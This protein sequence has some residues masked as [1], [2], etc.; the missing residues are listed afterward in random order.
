MLKKSITGAESN[1]V[2]PFGRKSNEAVDDGTASSP[3]LSIKGDPKVILSG[4]PPINHH[5]HHA[6][7]NSL[8]GQEKG[9]INHHMHGKRTDKRGETGVNNSISSGS[10]MI[11]KVP[12]SNNEIKYVKP[13]NP[14]K[15]E[16]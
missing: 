7:K 6:F 5:N 9:R 8:D 4:Q 1:Q 3:F 2:S 11:V 14:D 16:E 12:S 13:W 10:V 15:G